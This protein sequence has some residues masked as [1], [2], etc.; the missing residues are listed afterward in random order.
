MIVIP[1]RPVPNQTLSWRYEGASYR[2][3]ILTRVGAPYLTLDKNGVR[4]TSN[5][6]MRS[7]APLPERLM[8]ID[9]D[10]IDEPVTSDLGSR[11]LLI[12]QPEPVK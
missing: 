1:L 4:V 9:I 8:L 12:Q 6:V 11:F 7:Y 3:S 5:R 10:G 2:A